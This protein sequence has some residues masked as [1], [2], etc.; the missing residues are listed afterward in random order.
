M[1]IYLHYFRH[2]VR[3][4]SQL[5]KFIYDA[6]ANGKIPLFS[7]SIILWSI[8]AHLNKKELQFLLKKL[9]LYSSSP[10]LIAIVNIA[11]TN[12]QYLQYE[13][14]FMKFTTRT[15]LKFRWLKSSTKRL[16]IQKETH[17]IKISD[18]MCHDSSPPF[19]WLS[20]TASLLILIPII[21]L[22]CFKPNCTC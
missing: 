18:G 16:F 13:E 10:V 4:D 22:N 12:Q 21:I 20:W 14:E 19:L 15:Y 11:K 1:Y 7:T 17:T 2:S 9:Y 5:K 6:W 8:H 3:T